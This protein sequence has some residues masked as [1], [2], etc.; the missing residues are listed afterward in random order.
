MPQTLRVKEGQ[1]YTQRLSMQHRTAVWKVGSILSST[2][3]I[4]HALLINVQDPLQ[5]KTISCTTL[6]NRMYY[7]LVAESAT[8]IG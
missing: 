5:T 3:A 4:P 7:Q 8:G 2:V 1:R 6:A